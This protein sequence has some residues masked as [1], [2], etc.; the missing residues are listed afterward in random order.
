MNP[1]LAPLRFTEVYVERPWG[2]RRLAKDFRKPIGEAWLISDRPDCQS[3]VAQGPLAGKSLHELLQAQPETLLGR[4]PKL[5]HAGQFPLLLKLL[6]V[7][8]W[9][10]VQVHPNDA[11]AKRLGEADGG[12]TEM[13]HIIEAEPDAELLCGLNEGARLSTDS[14]PEGAD[15]SRTLKTFAPKA[16]DSFHV[17]AQTIHALGPGLLLAEIQQTSDLTY[18][19]Y[20]WDRAGKDGPRELHVEKGLSVATT[21]NQR[22]G[23]V[24]PV[25]LDDCR[26]LLC[27][28]EYFAAERIEVHGKYTRQTSGD[29]FHLV[30]CIEG[31]LEAR[32]S[33]GAETVSHGSALL[34]P[35]ACR[36]FSL[37]GDGLAVD[38]YVPDLAKALIPTLR[39]LGLGPE[40]IRALGRE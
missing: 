30:L 15:W 4:I 16:G 9:L 31:E 17:P 23:L 12:K 28:C 22:G 5:T 11:D 39:G 3:V 33:D 34:I 2:G 19:L 8:G 24:K 35:G 36:E 29:S 38:Y 37:S 40:D 1:L 14:P 13:W 7:A 32:T 27:A 20:D 6:D 26:S 18:R 25:R 21:E 10:S